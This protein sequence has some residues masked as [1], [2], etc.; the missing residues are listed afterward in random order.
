M[1][2]I[3]IRNTSVTSHTKGSLSVEAALVLPLFII[4]LLSLSF[5]FRVI[6][7]E[8]RLQSAMES[9]AARASIY[10]YLA[11]HEESAGE[12]GAA[13]GKEL[14]EMILQG[15]LTAAYLQV[16]TISLL[17]A[18]VLEKSP[19][20]GGALGLNPIGSALPDQEGNIDFVLHYTVRIPFLPGK[21]GEIE[22]SQ[23]VC[24]RIWGGTQKTESEESED[25]DEQ[26]VFITETGTVYHMTKDCRHLRLSVEAV[27]AIE[28][29]LMRSNDGSIYYPCERCAD[30]TDNA[31]V[32]ITDDGN[33]YHETLDCPGLK[34]TITEIPLSQ[35]GNRSRC[36][37]CGGSVGK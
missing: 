34:R 9:A 21:F 29:D 28:I 11:N 23:R 33:R 16:K 2:I 12:I 8:H 37:T 1:Q 32:Y 10:V 5:L 25:S 26:M 22:L 17:G 24:R 13:E 35:T 6:I 36:K 15:G 19:V 3:R 4:A 18:D 27:P 14:M 31:M 30:L 7:F 20:A